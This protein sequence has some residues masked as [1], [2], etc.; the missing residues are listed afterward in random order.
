[1]RYNSYL[2]NPE[3]LIRAYEYYINNNLT[4]KEVCAKFKICYHTFKSYIGKIRGGQLQKRN[5]SVEVKTQNNCEN[6][7]NTTDNVFKKKEKKNDVIN[8]MNDM[9]GRGKKNEH[10]GFTDVIEKQKKDIEQQNI[11]Q[12][13]TQKK[14]KVVSLDEMY[15]IS[16]FLN[17]QDKIAKANN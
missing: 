10:S 3:P 7:K 17:E 12:N 6:E 9:G 16:G 8:V 1:M 14:K 13:Q 4:Q 2:T 11:N 5:F 15:N